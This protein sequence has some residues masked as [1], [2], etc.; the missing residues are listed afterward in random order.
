M[1]TATLEPPK[2]R[3]AFEKVRSIMKPD[4]RGEDA[5]AEVRALSKR[6]A[7][8]RAKHSAILDECKRFEA[9]VTAAQADFAANPSVAAVRPLIL[10][11]SQ[12]EAAV[13]L[14][15]EVQKRVNGYYGDPASNEFLAECREKGKDFLRNI[16]VKAAS[17]RLAEARKT[18]D[19]EIKRARQTLGQE[20]FDS[21]ELLKAPRV[22]GAKGETEKFERL[23]SEIETAKPEHVWQSASKILEK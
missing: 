7:E 23:I 2:K 3:S 4:K 20:G 8:L 14:R 11:T 16:L 22:R 6:H 18:Y 1:S 15:I 17:F 21:E 9:E 10:L 13:N 5:I 12:S 19:A